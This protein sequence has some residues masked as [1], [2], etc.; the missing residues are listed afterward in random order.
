MQ[1]SKLIKKFDTL[2]DKLGNLEKLISDFIESKK[3]EVSE[4]FVMVILIIK[5]FI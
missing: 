4:R 1:N 5:P 2:N 3:E